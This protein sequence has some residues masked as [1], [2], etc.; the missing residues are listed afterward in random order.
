MRGVQVERGM[1][2]TGFEQDADGVTAT[3]DGDERRAH[4]AGGLPRRCRRRAQRRAQG[5]RADLRGRGVRRAVHA[6][7]RR[8]RLVDAARLR[9]PG[10]APDRRQDRR[11]A[12]VHSAAGPRPLPDVDAGARRA[13]RRHRPPTGSR[14]VSRA[15]A[16]PNCT[17]SRPCWTG[18]R[19]SRRP[20]EPAVVLGLPDQPPHRRRLRARPGVRRRRRRPHPPADRRAGHEHRHPGRAQPGLEARARGV[21]DTPPPGC[22]TATTPNGAR[23]RG[24]RGP[25]RAQCP[26]GHRRRLIRMPTSSSA[27]RPSCSSATPTARSSPSGAA[28]RRRAPPTPRGLTRDAV[29]GPLRLFSLLGRREHTML[30]YAGDDAAPTTSRCSSGPPRR[31]EAAHGHMDVYLIA[32]P[33]ADVATTV[34][35]LVRDSGGEFARMYSAPGWSVYVVRPDGYLG[36]AGGHRCR[37]SGRPSAGRLSD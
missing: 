31:R 27:A 1:R 25:H 2:L 20:R 34:L 10:D 26:R 23:R 19:P 24:G 3:L 18:C 6:R 35:P 8:G 36:F 37:R 22:W 21:R 29:A 14:T 15:G 7:R 32:A 11:P 30:L 16:S 13:R 28:P 17:T 5:A 9:H 12:G 33:N 4:A